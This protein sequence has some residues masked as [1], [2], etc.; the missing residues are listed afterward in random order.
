ML[1]FCSLLPQPVSTPLM[2]SSPSTHYSLTTYLPQASS[3]PPVLPFV[4]FPA[5]QP[6]V[7]VKTGSVVCNS[8]SD[9]GLLTFCCTWRGERFFS[10]LNSVTPHQSWWL[11]VI[12]GVLTWLYTARMKTGEKVGSWGRCVCCHGT[13]CQAWP[14]RWPVGWQ[15]TDLLFVVWNTSEENV[16]Q[17]HRST[18]PPPEASLC[19]PLCF[20]EQSN[21]ELI[22]HP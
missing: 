21:V 13:K 1:T 15:Q 16:R 8:S 6:S 10:L 19:M 11:L 4:L 9:T 7:D 2:L 5:D 22:N 20:Y 14:P 18:S 12:S 3:P 17:H